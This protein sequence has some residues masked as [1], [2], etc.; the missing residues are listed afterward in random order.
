MM[1]IRNLFYAVK[2][3]EPDKF[4]E[5]AKLELE[6]PVYKGLGEELKSAALKIPELA[7]L[8]GPE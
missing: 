1:L 8:V 6:Q 2:S 3:K 4:L 7:P 5:T